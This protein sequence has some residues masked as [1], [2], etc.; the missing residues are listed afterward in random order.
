M[1]ISRSSPVVVLALGVL[2]APLALRAQFGGPGAVSDPA[3]GFAFPLP[4]GWVEKHN[5]GGAILGHMVIA[6]AV[7]VVPHRLTD[8]AQLPAAMAQGIPVDQG[9]L[10]PRTQTAAG[11]AGTV[12]GDFEL[13]G[14]GGTIWARVWGRTLGPGGG[15]YVMAMTQPAAFTQA[16]IDTAQQVAGGLV[17]AAQSPPGAGMGMGMAGA[18]GALGDTAFLVGTWQ[19]MTKNTETGYTLFPDGTWTSS[20]TSSYTGSIHDQYG[21]ETANWGTASD[22]HNRGRWSAQ[23]NRQQGVLTLSDSSGTM[24][25]PYQVHVEKGQVYPNEYYFDGVLYWKSN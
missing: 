12:V 22:T 4:Q 16:L 20:R 6:G 15:A 24:Q 14:S 3:W 9:R 2:F 18:G 25:V 7:L 5:Q 10:V 8:P 11:P 13:E 19:S 21:G 23:G 1:S 17:P